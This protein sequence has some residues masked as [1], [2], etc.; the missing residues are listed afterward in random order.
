M[1]RAYPWEVGSPNT[2]GV[3]WVEPY[4]TRRIVRG[5]RLCELRGSQEIHANG[6]ELS[7]L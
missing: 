1:R 3:R 2:A 6:L 5:L 7:K 4:P